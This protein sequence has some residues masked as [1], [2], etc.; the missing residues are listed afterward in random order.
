[1]DQG[2]DCCDDVAVFYS[3]NCSYRLVSY[4][5]EGAASVI[6]NISSAA[7]V[8]LNVLESVV[9]AAKAISR[10]APSQID[11]NTAST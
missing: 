3:K 6:A 1:M 4:G 7:D 2:K 10:K 8:E 5:E 9:I 11:T